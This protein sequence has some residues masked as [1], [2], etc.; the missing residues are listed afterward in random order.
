MIDRPDPAQHTTDP[1]GP[2]PEKVTDVRPPARPRWVVWLVIGIGVAVLVGIGV[3]LVMGGG[4]MDHTPGMNHHALRASVVR[5]G[6]AGYV[7]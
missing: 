3:H 2:E 4:P 5:G 1:D 7:A 6:L